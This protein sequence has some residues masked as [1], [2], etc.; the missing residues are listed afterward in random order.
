MKR[1]VWNHLFVLSSMVLGLCFLVSMA[2]ELFPEWQR[3][4]SEYYRRLAQ[5]TG[6]PSKARTPLKIRQIVLPEMNR[7]DRC[8]TCHAGIDN[9]KMED[10]PQP[11]KSHPDLGI[12]GFLSKHS[13]DEM[14]CTVCHQGQGPATEKKP[15]HGP[16]P[17]W[18]EPLLSKELVVGTCT[19]CHQ[20]VHNLPGAE[21]LVKAQAL[22]EEKGCVGCHNLHGKGMLV[23][24]ELDETWRKGVHSYDFRYVRGEETVANWVVE[25][26]RDP[27]RVVPGYPALGVPESPMPNYELTEEENQLLTTLMLS[28]S[29]ETEDEHH[30]VPAR[31]RV[32]GTPPEM[33]PLPAD[34]VERGRALFLKY[35]CVGCH[36]VEGRGGVVNKN[37]DLGEVPTLIYVSGGY[38]REEIKEI[39]REGKYPARAERGQA[40]P[41][42]WMPSWKQKIPDEEIDAM[43]EYLISLQPDA[44]RS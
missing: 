43:V 11:F 21:K 28:F 23:G 33:K 4:Q 25:H 16:V 37:M 36:G 17:H 40:S 18:E 6:D 13:F 29:S 31:F 15:A 20:N 12:P 5:V 1:S 30:P 44:S 32:T 22:F 35:G 26:F 10:Q 38:S 34:P 42:L 41:P 7:V 9:P 8:V 27:Q 14:G 24:P 19:A 39:I 2:G 3:T